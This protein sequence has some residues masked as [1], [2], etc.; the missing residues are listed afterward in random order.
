MRHPEHKH[1]HY[2]RHFELGESERTNSADLILTHIIDR[3][4]AF[5]YTFKA[6]GRR[7]LNTKEEASP[8]R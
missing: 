6:V 7:T 4:C 8:R 5:V 1:E 2:L 3:V